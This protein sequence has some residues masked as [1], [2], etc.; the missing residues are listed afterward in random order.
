[1]LDRNIVEEEVSGLYL[2]T[3]GRSADSEGVAY[4]VNEVMNGKLTVEQVGQ[5]FFDQP[6]VQSKYDGLE[7]IDF[8]KAVYQNV[9]GRE[10]E[11]E[12]LD[13]WV[14]ELE[15]GVFSS[16][17]FIEAVN[18]SA[19]GDDASRLENMKTVGYYYMKEVGVNSDLASKIL[20]GIGAHTDTKGDGIALVDFYKSHVDN[21]KS[22]AGVEEEML[23]EHLSDDD[24]LES[25]G[26]DAEHIKF[27]DYDD[28]FWQ[29]GN[30]NNMLDD[31]TIWASEDEGF[32]RFQNN[33]GSGL[34]ILKMLENEMFDSDDM[35]EAYN[36]P[37]NYED[38]NDKDDS[39]DTSSY[40]TLDLGGSAPTISIIENWYKPDTTTSWQW[41]LDGEINTSYDVD[42]YDVDLFTTSEATIDTLHNDGKKV[43]A[44]FSA[45]SY[46]NWREDASQFDTDILGNNLD[47]WE[48][49][50]WLDIRSESVRAIIIQRLD[51]AVEKD[52]D[53]V[54]A[55]NVDGYTNNTGFTLSAQDQLEFN[56]FLAQAAHDRGL[57]IGLKN[58]VDQIVELE[59]YFD[60]AVNEEAFIYE[61]SETMIPFIENSK[62]VFNAEYDQSY[63]YNV[64]GARDDLF[65]QSQDLGFQTLVLPLGLD[66]SF[67]YDG[68]F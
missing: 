62:P 6:E 21:L 48:G 43:I 66:D 23:W 40:E 55:D 35:Y 13:Y 22:V 67:R 30:L 49:E 64:D 34:D 46:E 24:Y 61:E 16:N 3:I 19:L 53:G 32:L 42:L 8:V 52:F 14:G 39:S 63:I 2:T 33:D 7:T 18:N 56:M 25:L 68:L 20:E 15:S 29:N 1:M 10:A 59:P 11:E 4:W 31:N 58:D 38:E 9:L 45:G 36:T 47:G 41:Q 27:K 65:L 28:E 57:S 54:E 26:V 37:F 50:R 60:F 12:G 17:R 44:Y 5:S 51:L